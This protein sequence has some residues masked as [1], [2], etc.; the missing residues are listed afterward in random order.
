[1]SIDTTEHLTPKD[2]NVMSQNDP[3]LTLRFPLI[4]MLEQL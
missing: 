2:Q 3:A 4:D 1:M